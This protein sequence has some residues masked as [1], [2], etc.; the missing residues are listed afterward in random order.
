MKFKSETTLGPRYKLTA[1]DIVFNIVNYV[2]LLSITFVCFFPF[3]YLF[4]NTISDNDLVLRGMITFLPKG[5]HFQNYIML[6]Y[7]P[8]LFQ[9]IWITVSRTFLG[10]ALMVVFSAF[11]GFIV[12]S[13]NMWHRKFVY[14]FIIIPMYFNAGLIPWYTTMLSLGLTKNYLGYILPGLIV[15]FNVIMVKTYVES[16]SYEMQ[17]SAKI[18]G[19]GIMTIF[20]KIIWPLSTP[21]LATIAIFGAVSNWNS[22][23]DS[24]LLMQ[25]QSDLYTLQHRLYNYLTQ[26]TNIESLM[27]SG[28]ASSEVKKTL[29]I[30][31][32][33][34]TVAMVSIIPVLLVYPF[35]QRYFV[36]GIMIGAVKG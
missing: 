18:D 20:I 1:G 29:N 16:I 17:E 22:F 35:M 36:Q 30:N 11:T 19:A 4:I 13:R 6:E 23:Q 9:S 5:I 34:Y 7:I 8:D 27:S 2:I 24:I 31:V 14:R 21:I 10:T 33:R 25:G 12:S 26:S 15:P 3:Y 32:V 28:N